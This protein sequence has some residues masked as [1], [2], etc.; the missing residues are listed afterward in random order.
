MMLKLYIW[1]IEIFL[2]FNQLLALCVNLAKCERE[3]VKRSEI[4]RTSV[5]LYIIS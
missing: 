3:K 2:I 5:E 1:G 4:L